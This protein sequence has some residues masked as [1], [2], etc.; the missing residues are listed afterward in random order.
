MF[1]NCS[2]VLTWHKRCLGCQLN[3]C[4]F[5]DS[6]EFYVVLIWQEAH[7]EWLLSLGVYH[8]TVTVWFRVLMFDCVS[9]SKPLCYCGWCSWSGRYTIWW[10]PPPG[11]HTNGVNW[12]W[13]SKI[14]GDWSTRCVSFWGATNC[15]G[16]FHLLSVMC[17]IP[18]DCISCVNAVLSFQTW[19]LAQQVTK[20]YF[21]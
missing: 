10:P 6:C 15:W 7:D 9:I 11:L 21:F 1:K 2:P 17:L 3:S 20:V 19:I 18:A 12:L 5:L 4:C 16:F 13:I 14:A 8:M